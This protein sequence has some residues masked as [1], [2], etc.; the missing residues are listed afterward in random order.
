[1]RKKVKKLCR[2]LEEYLDKTLY[3]ISIKTIEFS[4]ISFVIFY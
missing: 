2:V 3:N 4:L 1:M